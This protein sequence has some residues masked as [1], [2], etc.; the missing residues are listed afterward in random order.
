MTKIN[1]DIKPRLAQVWREYVLKINGNQRGG[2]E[3]I[4]EAMEEYLE[5]RGVVI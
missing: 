3:M 1:Y 2:R 5:K 4:E